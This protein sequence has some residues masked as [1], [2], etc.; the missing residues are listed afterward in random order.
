MEESQQPPVDGPCSKDSFRKALEYMRIQSTNSY[1]KALIAV[2]GGT[3]AVSLS[4]APAAIHGTPL[5]KTT[6]VLAWVALTLT[7]LCVVLSFFS[8]RQAARKAIDEL[9][10]CKERPQSTNCWSDI[11]PWLNAIGGLLFVVGIILMLIFASANF[12]A[13]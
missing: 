5:L 10:R 3:L 6:L 9:D 2:S 1:D 7:I 8:S 13:R 4:V 11:I 12:L